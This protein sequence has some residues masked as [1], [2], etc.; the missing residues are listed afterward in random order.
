MILV[1]KIMNQIKNFDL[2]LVVPEVDIQM[3]VWEPCE[4]ESYG[5]K[6]RANRESNAYNDLSKCNL[7][8]NLVFTRVQ[9]I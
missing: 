2:G 3:K 6:R 1:K 4:Y 9:I 7:R 5:S 8:N